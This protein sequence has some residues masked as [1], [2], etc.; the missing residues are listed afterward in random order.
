MPSKAA[1]SGCVPYR[2][3][4]RGEQGLVVDRVDH[5]C[6]ASDIGRGFLDSSIGDASADHIRLRNRRLSVVRL[7]SC[8]AAPAGLSGSELHRVAQSCVQSCGTCVPPASGSTR[9]MA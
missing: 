7:R 6:R 1:D 8:V 2:V 3:P 4:R 9:W 5:P